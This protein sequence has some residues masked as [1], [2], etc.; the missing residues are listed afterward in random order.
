MGVYCAGPALALVIWLVIW[1]SFI[2]APSLPPCLKALLKAIHKVQ[3]LAP[4]HQSYAAKIVEGS[5]VFL[6]AATVM[7][8]QKCRGTV[9][10]V[11]R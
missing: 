7:Q 1:L 6:P 3:L 10:V 4:L 9:V 2:V 8:R 5:R 11:S